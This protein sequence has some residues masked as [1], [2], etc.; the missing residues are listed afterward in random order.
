MKHH[1]EEEKQEKVL[2]VWTLSSSF[3]EYNIDV[4]YWWL[5]RINRIYHFEFTA[6][7]ENCHVTLTLKESYYEKLVYIR[8][9]F[10]CIDLGISR[11]TSRFPACNAQFGKQKKTA[12]SQI[13]LIQKSEFV[14]DYE[15]FISPGTVLLKPKQKKRKV[16]EIDDILPRSS[17]II[18]HQYQHDF[19]VIQITPDD[20]DVISLCFIEIPLPSPFVHSNVNLH[21][22]KYTSE[23]EAVTIKYK[24]E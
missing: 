24:G 2:G 22:S 17:F 19:Y 6:R 7:K 14:I 13:V 8:P 9:S 3:T 12:S 21:L 10:P 18:P 4:G 11:N 20:T 16:A 1:E 5:D 15:S 23:K